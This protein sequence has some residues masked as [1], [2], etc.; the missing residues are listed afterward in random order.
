M[1][2]DS[3]KFVGSKRRSGSI[4]L[5]MQN[6]DQYLI[7]NSL[8]FASWASWHLPTV[9]FSWYQ[10][11]HPQ[12]FWFLYLHNWKSHAILHVESFIMLIEYNLFNS[13]MQTRDWSH[14]VGS[15]SEKRNGSLKMKPT[16]KQ[17][18]LNRQ[19]YCALLSS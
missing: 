12:L 16:T 6:V 18:Y 5:R 2:N 19:N 11:C 3:V 7:W 8:S 13:M 9:A 14:A 10:R 17:K 1:T 4:H 15:F